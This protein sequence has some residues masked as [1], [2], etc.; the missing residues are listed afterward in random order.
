MGNE[1]FEWLQK[2][3]WEIPPLVVFL[4][5]GCDKGSSGLSI[6]SVLEQTTRVF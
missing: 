4:C 1:T 5:H 6:S 2:I 3:P